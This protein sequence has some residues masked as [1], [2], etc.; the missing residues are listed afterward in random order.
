VLQSVLQPGIPA[1]ALL[2]FSKLLGWLAG[3]LLLLLQRS[4]NHSFCC[5]LLLPLRHT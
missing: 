4:P 5:L 2:L 3:P 1:L